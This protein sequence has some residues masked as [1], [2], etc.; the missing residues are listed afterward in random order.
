MSAFEKND[1][2][3]MVIDTETS[4]IP[5]YRKGADAEGQPR[6]AELAIVFLDGEM[7]PESARAYYIR[8]NG[9]SM[10]PEAV[11]VNNLT[12]EYLREHGVDV[13]VALEAYSA[14]I[15]SGRVV[16]AH[17]AQFDCKIMR[18]ELRLAGMPD[19]FEQ[20]RNVCTMRSVSAN[21]KGQVK[22]L[23]GK[24]G[25]P[26]LIDLASHFGIHYPSGAHSATVDAAICAEIAR[27]MAE[28]GNLLAA[29]VH[30]AKE[31]AND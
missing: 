28:A 26:R 22:K 21:M 19:L 18:G 16:I 11:A 17:N 29:E 24:G 1:A 14:G 3:Y 6:L 8:P 25:Y 23:N 27:I 13:S 31:H 30:Y 4:G 2:G 10:S 5:D 15:M 12:D 9:W 20:T 7:M